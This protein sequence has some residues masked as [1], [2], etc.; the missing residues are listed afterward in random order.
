MP[1]LNGGGGDDL[2]ANDELISFKDEGE[3]EEKIS[4]NSSA[5]RDLADVKSSLV[6]E[7]ETNQ[8][9]SS[10]S[11]AERR[12]PPRSETF[13]DKSRESLEEAAKRQD[14]GLFKGPPYPGYPFI[15]IPDLSSPYLPNGSLSPTARTYLQMKWPLLDVQAGSLQSRQALKDARSPSPAHIVSNKVPV[16]QHPHHVHP[17]TPLITYS[18]EHFTPGNPPPHLP[19]D[20]DP[21]TGIPRPPHPPDISPY[22][23][24]SPGTVGQIPHPLGWQGQPVYPITTG[25]FRHPYPTALTVNASMSSFLSS[26]FPPHMVPPH[27]SLH[28]T[29]IP[30]PAI[31]TPTVKQESSQSDVGSLHSSKHQ[32][33]KKEEE[34][35]KPHIKKPL[36]AFMLYMKEMRAKVVAECTLKES[37]AINQILGRRWHALSREEQAK[38]YE[39]ARKERQLHMQLYPGWSARDNYGKKKKRKR[40][41]QPGETNEHSECFLNPCLSLPP[42]T[43]LSAPKKCRAR[44]GLDQQNNWC[45][46]CRCNSLPVSRRKKKCVRYIQGEG[47]CVSPPSS[48]GS[49]LDSPPSSPAMLAS[50]SRDSKPQTEQTQPLSLSLKPDPLAH[51]VMMPPPSS[52]VLTESAASKPGALPAASCPNGALDHPPAA[53]PPAAAASLAQPSTSSLHSH[54][55]LA[56]TQ[57]Q[58][59]SLVTKSLE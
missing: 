9:S 35:K 54:S 25:G 28:T 41:K 23:P 4:E 30:H 47:S 8:N 19:A 53:L 17:L 49:L 24:L 12:P 31:V 34:K 46:P 36:N 32:D 7:S 50:P 45:G 39:L 33:S 42:I 5:E 3:Q 10:D 29:G 40:D 6:N 48:D 38:Y 15:M 22:Y 14:G 2:G 51:L 37:A 1:Q 56:G 59:L 16:V 27:H 58:P 26:R 21:K 18:N 20:V 13:R 55:S 11:E 43:D 57:P 52:L 44:F